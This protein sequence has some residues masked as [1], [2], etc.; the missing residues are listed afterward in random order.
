MAE[1]LIETYS[2]FSHAL[3]SV[4]IGE[5]KLYYKRVLRCYVVS[6]ESRRVDARML[7]THSSVMCNSVHS[8]IGCNWVRLDR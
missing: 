5:Y 4:S 8:V 6:S 2:V 1:D 7:Q 3:V